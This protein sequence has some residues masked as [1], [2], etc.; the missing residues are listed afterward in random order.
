MKNKDPNYVAKLEKAIAE[1]Y[2][3]EAIQNPK[4]G[5]TPEKEKEYIEQVKKIQQKKIKKDQDV[6]KVETNGF[7]IKKKLLN[8]EEK[9]NCP[10]CE[11]YSLEIRDD[12]YMI[13]FDCCFKCYIQY[14]EDREERWK[15]GWRPNT[16]DKKNV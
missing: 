15:T 9:R 12:V 13:K 4:S 1:K 7:F 6:E 14:I 10:V 5:W 2:G 8:R 3:E 16:G 11:E